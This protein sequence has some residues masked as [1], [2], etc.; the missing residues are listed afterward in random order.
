MLGKV[1]RKVT[2]RPAPYYVD[3]P[4]WLIVWKPIRK[5][6]NVVVIPHVP[7][8]SLRRWLYRRIGFKIGRNVFIGMRCY[9]DD[10]DPAMTIIE[11]DA[12]IS[13]GCFFA[14]HG[15]NQE[16]M[17]IVIKRGAYL[18][19]RANILSGKEGIVIGRHAV[20]GAGALVNRSVPDGA[21]VVGVPA[22]IIKQDG[23][24]ELSCPADAH[25]DRE[26]GAVSG[27]P[28]RKA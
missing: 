2:G 8:T 26:G 16:H 14:C 17:P 6:V 3:Y 4:L 24:D 25:L 15:K 28:R 9:L 13:Y 7:F 19:M 5:Y 21:T 11:D 23:Q 1:F 10:V 12:V 27:D 20:V 18:G 22:R